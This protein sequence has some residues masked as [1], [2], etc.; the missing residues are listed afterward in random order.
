MCCPAFLWIQ[1]AALAKDTGKRWQHQ[2]VDFQP[3]PISEDKGTPKPSSRSL[4]V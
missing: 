1:R 3:E 2:A 4:L